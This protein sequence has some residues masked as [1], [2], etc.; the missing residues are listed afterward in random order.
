MSSKYVY[1]DLKEQFIQGG[2][3]SISADIIERKEFFALVGFLS[4]HNCL[5]IFKRIS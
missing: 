1:L 4:K 5:L 3:C 2:V